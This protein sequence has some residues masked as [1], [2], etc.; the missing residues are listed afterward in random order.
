MVLTYIEATQEELECRME[1][2]KPQPFN[3][4]TKGKRKALQEL[5]ERNDIVITKV[6]K[7]GTVVIRD[8]KDYIIEAESQLKYNGYY[9]R[10]KMIQQKHTADQ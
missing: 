1:N 6:D 10:L 7:G 8:I 9:D 3:N 2:Q 4:L 5:S